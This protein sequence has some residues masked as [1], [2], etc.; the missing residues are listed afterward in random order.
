MDESI[1]RS[2]DAG[3]KRPGIMYYLKKYAGSEKKSYRKSVLLAF[4]GV[5]CGL[6]PYVILGDMIRRLL[7]DERNMQVYAA[8]CLI[9]SLA[10]ILRVLFH[11]LSTTLSHRTTFRVIAEVKLALCD[12]LA[13]LPLGTVLNISSGSLK[14]IIVERTDSMETTLAHIVPEFTANLTAPLFFFVYLL[15]LDWRMALVSLA[16]LPVGVLAMLKMSLGSYVG[17]FKKTQD[18]TKALNDAAVEYIN[19]IEVIKAFGK[20]ERSYAR[21]SHAAEANAASF[22]DWMHACVVPFSVAMV[23]TPST[24]LTVLPVGAIFVMHGSLSAVEY[25]MIIVLACGLIQPLITAMS[26]TDDINKVTSIFGE[27][28]DLMSLPEL[29]R[30]EQS[31]EQPSGHSIVL[32]HVRFGYDGKEVLHDVSLTIP[33]GKVTALVG[34]SG[35][36]KSTIARLV[37][38]LWDVEE[39]SITIG[40]VDVRRLSLEDS[41]RQ[42]AFVSQSSFLFDTT[43]RENIRMGRPSATDEEVEAIARESGC[44]DFIMQL[45]QGYDTIVGGSGAHLSGGERQRISIARAMLKDAPIL[46][47]DEATAYTDPENEALIQYSVSR[48]A[49]GKTMLVIAHRL[50]TVMNSDKIVVVDGGCISCE[51][52]HEELL[53]ASPLYEKMWRAHVSTRDIAEEGKGGDE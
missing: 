48:L 30:P 46:I 50:T 52:T 38:S 23:V 35:S 21:F 53:T 9:M 15:F 39:G 25:I 47:L 13:R 10:W 19:G 12:K 45:A 22:I 2:S 18:T 5:I 49:R 44:H 34:P 43:V 37:D 42:M 40:G 6:A 17:P 3:S 27:I 4:A 41:A 16:T 31:A 33:D 28:D 24:L 51:G 26:Y 14:N 8:G 32:S 7:T 36:G 29:K 11:T 1:D 20:A